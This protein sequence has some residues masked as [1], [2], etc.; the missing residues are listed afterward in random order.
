MKKEKYETAIHTEYIK[1]EALLK[2]AG[3]TDTGG[4]AK[5]LILDGEVSVN[6]QVCLQRGKKLYPGDKAELEG[7]EITVRSEE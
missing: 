7:L 2:Y 4:D 1:L 3:V 5:Q 6:G